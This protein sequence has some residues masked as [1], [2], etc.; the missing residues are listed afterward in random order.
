MD[1]PA[2]IDLEASGFGRG[3]YPIE[4][5][6]ALADGSVFSELIRPPEH[7]VH[8]SEDA[9]AIHGITRP[10]LMEHGKTPREVAMQLNDLLKVRFCLA[11]LGALTALGLAACLMR[12]D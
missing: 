2:I 3:S 1:V 11:M 4:V 7:W 12:P 5:G 6:V 8:W 10:Q 9:E